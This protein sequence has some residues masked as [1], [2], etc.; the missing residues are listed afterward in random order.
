MLDK[1]DDKNWILIQGGM[2]ILHTRWHGKIIPGGL[3]K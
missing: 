2:D 1:A 3:W